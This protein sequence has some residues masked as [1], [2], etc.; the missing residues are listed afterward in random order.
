[1]ERQDSLAQFDRTV[2][3]F[4]R[5]SVTGGT[6]TVGSQFIRV[7][8]AQFPD[9]RRINTTCRPGSPRAHRIQRHDRVNVLEG[10]L[11]D[12]HVLTAV[13]DGADVVYHLAAWLAN[14]EL[15]S[16]LEVYL[17]NSLATG[18]ISRL[19]AQ[20]GKPL[21]F[22]SSHSVYFAGDYA[23][24][25]RADD[26]VFR[27]DFVEWIGE[28]GDEYGRLI[29]SII[30]GET[31]LADAP[32]AVQRIHEQLP[33]PFEPKIY[34]SDSY[35]IYCLTKLLAERFVLDDGGVVLRLS[36]VYGPGDESTQA[37]AEACQ[38]LLAARPGDWIE[39]RQ[40]FKKL[41]P[42]YLGDIFKAFVR[43]GR[44]RL[45]AHEKAVFTVASQ[46]DYM[47]EDELLRTV[48]ESLNRIGGTSHEYDIEQLPPED[49]TAFTYDLT[50]MN[51]YLLKTEEMTP[52]A[53]GVERQ[54]RWLM[55]R[56]EGAAA[57]E[58]AVVVDFAGD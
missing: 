11:C 19:C 2:F 52:F 17:T 47:R 22:T 3:P 56:R 49:G 15:P 40:P 32:R 18:V 25:I 27:E 44:L 39:V 1:M 33:P 14:T 6:G 46:P 7:L 13:V 23:G 43:A 35:H 12:L 9:V 20:R 34:D 16:L 37:V 31:A 36:N 8:L 50:R 26:Y 28:A 57:G 38:R 29:D 45:P 58:W 53:E 4:E 30:A 24:R 54:L 5:V 42:V 21:V 51:A 41:V 10:D 55:A 48:A